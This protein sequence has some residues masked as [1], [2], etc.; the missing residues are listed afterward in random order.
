MSDSSIVIHAHWYQPPRENPFTGQVDVEPSAAPFH[1]WNERISA[2]C[3]SPNSSAVIL[4]DGSEVQRLNNYEWVG[5]DWGPTILSWL[6]THRRHIYEKIV[7][8]DRSS[9][10]RFGGHGSAIAHAYNH[11]ILPL[12]NQRDK[13][14][15]VR[16]GVADFKHRFE[17]VPEGMW[18]PE[19]AVDTETLEVLAAEGILFTVLSPLQA[20]S[21]LHDGAW[22]DVTDGSLNTSVPYRVEL[23]SGTPISVFFYDGPLSSEIAFNGLLEDGV[24]MASRLV[25]RARSAGPGTLV[26]VATDGETYGHHHRHGEMALAKAIRILNQTPGVE[27]SSYGEFLSSHPPTRQVRLVEGSSWSCA[28]GVERWRADCGCS[29]STDPEWS[30]AWRAPLRHALD[31][32]RDALAADFE[33]V[34]GTFA[35]RVWEARD[36]YIEVILGG[37]SAGFLDRFSRG[38]APEPDRQA[39]LKLLEA[40]RH[41]MLMYTSCGWFFDDLA[42]L[43]SVLV[44]RQAGR[45]MQLSRSVTGRDHEPGFLDRLDEAHSNVDGMTGRDIFLESVVPG[46]TARQV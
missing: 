10:S 32:L 46:M 2:E 35:D 25:D 21:V 6:E 13:V 37:E 14:T 38:G 16:W 7:D 23:P 9:V 17:R 26:S 3:Y 20:Q 28:H 31:W 19:T 33:E 42:G 27:L 43:E 39:F 8:A 30:Q 45:A 40:Q 34:G 24:D 22:R 18:L 15:Q 44:L 12:S 1:D 29:M 5:S 41:S 11:M 4:E 36:A